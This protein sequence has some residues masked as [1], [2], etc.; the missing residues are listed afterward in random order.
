MLLSDFEKI[1][2]IDNQI[3]AL[4]DHLVALYRQRSGLVKPDSDPKTTDQT[5]EDV[6]EN[7]SSTNYWYDRLAREWQERGVRIPTQKVLTAKLK[8]A[9]ATINTLSEEL[10]VDQAFF[11]LVLIPPKSAF[12]AQDVAT[13]RQQQSGVYY[14]DQCTAVRDFYKPPTNWRLLVVY[15]GKQGMLWGS[16]ESIMSDKKYLIGGLDTRA[17]GV[18]EYA[19]YSL[20]SASAREKDGWTW[21][22]KHGA[23][24]PA[25]VAFISGAYHFS[26]DDP[27]G[28]LQSER[29]RPAVE[30]K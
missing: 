3:M 18:Y 17:L 11:T 25:S 13:A 21:L 9:V 16:A 26:T 15:N 7:T 12:A 5:S 6:P 29:F 14:P 10:H 27:K 1:E 19:I 4:Q 24:Q 8:T 28:Y 2:A 23:E 30:V 22:L 20:Q